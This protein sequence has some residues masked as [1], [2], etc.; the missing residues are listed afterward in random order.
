MFSFRQDSRIERRET[1]RQPPRYLSDPT[2]PLPQREIHR[3]ALGDITNKPRY[4][5]SITKTIKEVSR[6]AKETESC[7][8]VELFPYIV[9]SPSKHRKSPP[10]TLERREEKIEDPHFVLGINIDASEEE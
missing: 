4:Q 2:L 6:N 9:N 1:Q 3:P 5:G 8:E 7:T 10:R